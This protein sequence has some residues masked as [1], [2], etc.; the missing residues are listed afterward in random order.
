MPTTGLESSHGKTRHQSRQRRA[1]RD[2]K[3]IRSSLG[4]E[5]GSQTCATVEDDCIIMEVVSEDLVDKT[6][7]LFNG[8]PSLSAA[9]PRER[10]ADKG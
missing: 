1:S 2:S 7:G 5:P 10:H 4:I 9:L 8:G 3:K 6:R